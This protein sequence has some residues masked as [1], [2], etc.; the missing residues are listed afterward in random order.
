MHSQLLEAAA[1]ATDGVTS[2]SD[3]VRSI[4]GIVQ[5]LDSEQEAEGHHKD[6]CQ[7]QQATTR[8]HIAEHS[9]IVDQLSAMHSNLVEVIREKT[10]ALVQNQNSITEETEAFAALTQMREDGK[11]EFE[12]NREETVDAITALNQAIDILA[13]FYSSQAKGG[14]SFV[15]TDPNNGRQVVN[16]IARVRDEFSDAKKHLEDSE[17]SAT[18]AFETARTLHAQMDADLHAEHNT[19]S[20]ELQTAQQAQSANTD[21]K[22][23]QV[24]SVGSARQYLSKLSGACGPLLHNFDRRRDLRSQEKGALRDAIKVL[25]DAS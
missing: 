24:A 15:Q 11:H 12:R 13:Q 18:S 25:E 4:K 9:A 6:W 5:Q 20:V 23:T 17:A 14:A 8:T 22:N 1:T 7:D 19:L 16:M 21:D 10:Y 2:L 3:V